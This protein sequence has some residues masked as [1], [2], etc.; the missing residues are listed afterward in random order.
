M[1]NRG[2]HRHNAAVMQMNWPSWKEKKREKA[3]R[4]PASR[5]GTGAAV[6][7]C[8]CTGKFKIMCKQSKK[9]REE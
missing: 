3:G 4:Q 6:G 2:K 8:S 9:Q 7:C 5:Q 1:Y